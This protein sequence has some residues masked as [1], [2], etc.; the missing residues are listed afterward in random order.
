MSEKLN[1]TPKAAPAPEETAKKQI[2]PALV[3]T[4]ENWKKFEL[5]SELPG[6]FEWRGETYIAKDLTEIQL[7][8]LAD[9]KAFGHIVRKP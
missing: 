8:K 2:Y 4:P 5:K 7:E 6:K 9:D 1:E 3:A